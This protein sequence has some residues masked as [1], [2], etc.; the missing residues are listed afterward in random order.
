MTRRFVRPARPR[1]GLEV[2]AR[3]RALL[4]SVARFRYMTADHL[5]I[6]TAPSVARRVFQRRLR[7]LYEHGLVERDR[8]PPSTDDHRRGTP[9]YSLGDAGELVVGDTGEA[10]PHRPSGPLPSTIHHSLIAADFLVAV[11]EAVRRAAGQ[12]QA[13]LHPE[14][15]L[16]TRLARFRLRSQRRRPAIVPDG[17]VTLTEPGKV[18]PSTYALEVVRA[19]IRGGSRTFIAKLERYGELVR[20]RFF[21]EAFGFERLRAVVV[22]TPTST[23]ARN[24]RELAAKA[25]ITIPVVCVAYGQGAHAFTADSVVGPV[26]TDRDGRPFAMLPPVCS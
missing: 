14:A 22:A 3:D 10:L 24:L 17:A 21:R 2:G 9:L 1:A 4:R 18:T 12:L 6:L 23:R 16:W 8:L 13:T 11:H 20:A 7:L 5:R 26:F 19:D 15:E 25:K